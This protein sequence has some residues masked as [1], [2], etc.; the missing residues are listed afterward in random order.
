MASNWDDDN[1]RTTSRG[2][3]KVTDSDHTLGQLMVE[4]L[5]HRRRI[6]VL[7]TRL[8][9]QDARIRILETKTKN[10]LSPQSGSVPPGRGSQLF[11]LARKTFVTTAVIIAAI[12][13]ALKELGYLK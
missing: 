6:E 12:I 11:I 9:V 10:S 13:S 8:D 4:S 1:E 7:E 3:R 2:N 5:N